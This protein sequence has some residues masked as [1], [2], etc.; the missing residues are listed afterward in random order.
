[1]TPFRFLLAALLVATLSGCDLFGES[2]PTE[3]KTIV[4]SP[5][6]KQVVG[7][8]NDFGVDLFAQ[9]AAEDPSNLML[10]PLSAH[11][12]LT[13][14][15]NGSAGDTYTQIR[16]M[17]GYTSDM[18]L[19]AINQNYGTIRTQLLAADPSVQFSLANA[20]FYDQF[21]AP[22]VRRSFLATM[23]GPFDATVKDLSFGQPSALTTI[24][25]WA[26]SNTNGRVPRVLDEI[27][28][29]TIL[30]LMNA[31]YFNGDWST[32]FDVRSTAPGVF[33]LADQS[34][35][36]VPFMSGDLPARTAYGQGY[37]AL[38]LPYGRKNFSMVL[39]QSD[40]GSLSDLAASLRDGQWAN[41]EAQLDAQDEWSNILVRMPKF[42]FS[43][44]KTLNDQLKALGMV[45]AFDDALA[46]LDSL[47]SDPSAYVSF[48]KQ[49]TFLRVDEQG[50][51][52]AAV[53]TVGVGTTSL[54]P[55]FVADKPF[56]FVIRE[57]TTGTILF[58]GQVANPAL[59]G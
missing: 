15:L 47:T 57:R 18:D 38:E 59:T 37:Q 40:E 1:M 44:E 54:P 5:L 34:E 28:P 42:S 8:S 16:D 56:I 35:V 20:I 53:T 19:A 46:N 30:F 31:L 45:D 36:R 33:T 10:S 2:A 49:N 11:I 13:M 39:V 25:G 29:Q 27:E 24:N 32:P 4:L 3:P 51:E 21:Y 14:L 22:T 52:A 55:S 23:D 7:E 17:L 12:A 6:G 41:I 50:T 48:V 58:I 9:V 43:Y 26:S